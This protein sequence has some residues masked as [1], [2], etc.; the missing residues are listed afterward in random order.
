L[1]S[2]RAPRTVARCGFDEPKPNEGVTN[3]RRVAHAR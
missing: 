3:W 1:P 2:V